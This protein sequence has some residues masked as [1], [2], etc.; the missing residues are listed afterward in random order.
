MEFEGKLDGEGFGRGGGH[1]C[2]FLVVDF[3][4]GRQFAVNLPILE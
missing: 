2:R 1:F 4:L 3:V